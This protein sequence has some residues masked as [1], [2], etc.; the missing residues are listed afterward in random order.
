[1]YPWAV[2]RQQHGTGGRSPRSPVTGEPSGGPDSLS[3][4]ELLRNRLDV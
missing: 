3:E 4:E 1:M 2:Y